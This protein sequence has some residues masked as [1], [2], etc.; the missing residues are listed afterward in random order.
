MVQQLPV[1]KKTLKQIIAGEYKHCAREANY[2]FKKYCIIQHPKRGKVPFILYPFQ[3]DCTNV[4]ARNRGTEEAAYTII[5]KS[6]QLGLSTLTAAYA[7]WL[8]L[9]NEDQNILVIATKKEVAKNLITK[10][11]VMYDG[12]PSWLKTQTLEDNKMSLAF[13]NGSQIKAVSSSPTAGRSE[14][15]SLLIIDEAAFVRDI[16]EIWGAAKST[17]DTGGDCIVLSTPNG[18]G[19]W[20]YDM[21]SDATEKKN[22]FE[23]ISLKWTVHPERDQKWRD[24]QD[25][26]L[27]VRLASQECDAD[28]L[29]SGNN[30][31]DLMTLKF[32]EDSFVREPNEKRSIDKG[33]WI[34]EYP[35]YSRSYII[36]ADVARGDGSDYS[37]FH[38]FDAESLTQVAEYKGQA[39]TREYGRLLAAVGVEY[40]N[41]L[42]VVERE[43]VGWDTIQELIDINYQNLFYSSNDLQYVDSMRNINNKINRD[44]KKMKP[45]FATTHRNRA[46]LIA[47]IERYFEDNNNED[48]AFKIYSQR[49]INELKVFI[50][51]HGK[52]EAQSG[53][54][55]DLVMSLGILL[56]VRDTALRLRSEGIELTKMALDRIGKSELDL[57]VYKPGIITRDPNEMDIGKEVISL[58]QFY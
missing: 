7:L 22:N 32:Y 12:L 41:A 38:V 10:V 57:G 23:T 47:K 36:A 3:E 25:V 15:L 30:V 16:V 45:G 29:A 14:A 50:W 9:F 58:K 33:L 5:L 26:D 6:R 51:N 24:K 13:K 43:N 11:R 20:F 46:L 34:W 39:N 17:L 55:D 56:W 21:W 1:K 8:M 52:A 18:M 40:N 44:M 37:A 4:F 53:R 49:L 31:V 54:N 48:N 19:N 27:G 35:D 42:I 2:F 28:F